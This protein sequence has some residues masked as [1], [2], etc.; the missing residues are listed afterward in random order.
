[1]SNHKEMAASLARCV[2]RATG[3]RIHEDEAWTALKMFLDENAS[4]YTS[5]IQVS[6]GVTRDGSWA[7]QRV[8]L[9]KASLQRDCAQQAAEAIKITA[10]TESDFPFDTTL[11]CGMI[12]LGGKK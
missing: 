7:A 4:F 2:G 3:I 5:S 8:N 1:M 11:R 10:E 12:V 6:G 9:A